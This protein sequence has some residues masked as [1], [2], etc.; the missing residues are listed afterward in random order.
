MNI[1][2]A[3]YKTT[4]F[5]TGKENFLIDITEYTE[6]FKDGTK[7]EMYGAWLYRNNIGIKS[8]IIGEMKKEYK[9]MTIEQ[10]VEHIIDYCNIIWDENSPY[11]AFDWYDIEYNQ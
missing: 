11:T 5:E 6:T 7:E 4:T 10:Y 2:K 3:A 1:K 9:H 8:Y